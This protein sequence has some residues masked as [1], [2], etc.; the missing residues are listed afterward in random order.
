MAFRAKPAKSEATLAASAAMTAVH[1]ALGI[2]PRTIP[3]FK[4][5]R[6]RRRRRAS[7][8][9]EALGSP[10]AAATFAARGALGIAPRT[11]PGFKS[12]RA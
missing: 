12:A 7:K 10:A 8:S 4:S 1:G 11:I 5:A 3:G 6:A 2:A 9:I